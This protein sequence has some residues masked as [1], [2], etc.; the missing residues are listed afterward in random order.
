MFTDMEKWV[1]VRRDVLVRGKS[2]RQVQRETGLAWKT[3]EKIL[4]HSSPPGYRHA[5]SCKSTEP[6]FRTPS[7][8]LYDWRPY[9]YG[10]R[11]PL[12]SSISFVLLW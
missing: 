2:K 8:P 11:G 6:S 3:L 7:K 5:Q 1:E 9:T 12:N 4:P 10:A